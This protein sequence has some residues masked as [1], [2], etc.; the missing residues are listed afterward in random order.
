MPKKKPVVT[1]SGLPLRLHPA[2]VNIIKLQMATVI[3][4]STDDTFDVA[5]VKDLA[6]R[7]MVLAILLF[8]K[9]QPSIKVVLLG[10]MLF[11]LQPAAAETVYD[12]STAKTAVATYALGEIGECPDFRHQYRN[13]THMRAQIVQRAGHQLVDGFQCQLT[14]ERVACY[15]GDL[16]HRKYLISVHSAQ[17]PDVVLLVVARSQPIDFMLLNV[18]PRKNKFFFDGF[19]LPLSISKNS[20]WHPT[21]IAIFSIEYPLHQISFQF[22]HDAIN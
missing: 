14:I 10:L 6:L 3:L 1:V 19:F 21:T 2:W 9:A 16:H 5:M 12:C 18:P 8:F 4:A 20:S 17:L 13:V 11:G 22:V 15:C 7:F